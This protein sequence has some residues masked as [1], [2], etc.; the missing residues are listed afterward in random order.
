MSL[1]NRSIVWTPVQLIVAFTRTAHSNHFTLDTAL[2]WILSNTP[3]ER[4]E[5]QMNDC[6]ET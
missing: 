3:A 2:P 4:E 1:Q 6:R 5:D